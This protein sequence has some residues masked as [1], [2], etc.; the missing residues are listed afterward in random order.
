M[1]GW[2]HCPGKKGGVE[3]RAFRARHAQQSF[4]PSFL[5]AQSRRLNF[6][7]QKA[8]R[9]HCAWESRFESM[10]PQRLALMDLMDWAAYFSRAECS[11]RDKLKW[12][13]GVTSARASTG[14][15]GSTRASAN[16]RARARPVRA[17]HGLLTAARKALTGL[18]V[19]GLPRRTVSI[20][21]SVQWS[22][23]AGKSERHLVIRLPWFP[24]L[25]I[26][27]RHVRRCW[28]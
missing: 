19:F 4:Q 12:L 1:R 7:W 13:N 9:L 17:C 2:R 10:G 22:S 23:Q 16:A 14:A 3:T 20:I 24:V 26:S 18:H 25:K 15:G 27:P 6:P 21:H 5:H 8:P 28:E 11:S